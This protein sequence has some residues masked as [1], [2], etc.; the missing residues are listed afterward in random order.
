MYLLS[1]ARWDDKAGTWFR[2]KRV[3]WGKRHVGFGVDYN[4]FR[5][6][7]LCRV[8]WRWG[9]FR[10]TLYFW[11]KHKV[12]GVAEAERLNWPCIVFRSLLFPLETV[13]IYSRWGN[14]YD[15]RRDVYTIEGQ[16]Y[17]AELMRDFASGLGDGDIFRV[18][19]LDCGDFSAERLTR[20]N[21]LLQCPHTRKVVDCHH[22][23]PE[24]KT[25]E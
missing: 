19:R 16:K 1:F 17:T 20:K 5:W 12:F 21:R 8:K 22:Y 9:G 10:Q 4:G 6:S 7:P 13:A 18:R 15:V 3:R 2:W 23:E 11:G 14:V 25:R 24:D